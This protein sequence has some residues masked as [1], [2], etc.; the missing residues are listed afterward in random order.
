[1]AAAKKQ[2]PLSLSR[3]WATGHR[4]RPERWLIQAL[5]ERDDETGEPLY[6]HD[7]QG[8]VD[9]AFGPTRYS[10]LEK[11][12]HG[13][14][15]VIGGRWVHAPPAKQPPIDSQTLAAHAKALSARKEYQEEPLFTLGVVVATPGARELLG[16]DEMR[17]FIARHQHG[18]WGDVSKGDARENE[19]ALHSDDRILSAYRAHGRTFWVITENDRS[20]TTVLLPE[21]N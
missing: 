7:E 8:W 5:H 3:Q 15:P 17:A 6:W 1:V 2:K 19:R 10:T 11:K 21:E 14:V 20:V 16:A 9:M 12:V 13:P 18:D 4:A